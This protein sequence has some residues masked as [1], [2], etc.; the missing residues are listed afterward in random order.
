MSECVSVCVCVRVRAC[1]RACVHVCAYV[2]ECARMCMCLAACECFSMH[3]RMHGY[4]F[5]LQQCNVCAVLKTSN[6]SIHASL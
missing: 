3:A 6:R 1:V 2:H 4:V 5:Q